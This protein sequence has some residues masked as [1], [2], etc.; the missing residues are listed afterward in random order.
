MP[1]LPTFTGTSGFLFGKACAANAAADM[2]FINKEHAEHF[3]ANKILKD[4]MAE[5]GF[6]TA[7][8]Y[9]YPPP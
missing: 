1:N 7:Y 5:H 3:A 8:A 4:L 6:Q 2:N 9:V